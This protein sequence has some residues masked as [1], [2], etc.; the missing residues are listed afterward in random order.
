MSVSRAV[1][2]MEGERFWMVVE[3]SEEEARLVARAIELSE[4]GLNVRAVSQSLGRSTA[5]VRQRLRQYSQQWN[6]G[7]PAPVI[8]IGGEN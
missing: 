2:E 4:L 1:V 3:G 7:S 6:D 5:W 8:R